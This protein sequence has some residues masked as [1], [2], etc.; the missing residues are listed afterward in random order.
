MIMELM[1]G[2][3]LFNYIIKRDTFSER[4]AHQI[5]TPLFDAVFYC[6][7][8][9]IVHRDLKPENL[10]LDTNELETAT[11]KISDFGLARFV[12]QESLATTTC[13]TPGYVAPEVLSTQ[14]YD[15]RCDYWSLAVIMFI[16]LSG[17]PP[18]YHQNNFELFEIIK[19]G[20]YNFSAPVWTEVSI[21]A[22]DLIRR[23]LRRNPEH[24]L[25]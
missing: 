23:L 22:K 12:T 2:G 3:E 6:H 1:R 20:K 18:F 7:S 5:M 8:L 11:I 14:S 17:S 16:M 10:L 24:R 19:K 9:G 25:T 13:G 15:H 4:L 21:E